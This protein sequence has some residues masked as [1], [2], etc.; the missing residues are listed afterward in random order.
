ME[1]FEKEYGENLG[2]EKGGVGGSA[3]GLPTRK[4]GL[5]TENRGA[6]PCVRYCLF[7]DARRRFAGVLGLSAVPLSLPLLAWAAVLGLIAVILHF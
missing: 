2:K 1:N 6:G 7:T 4:N 5:L 3:G